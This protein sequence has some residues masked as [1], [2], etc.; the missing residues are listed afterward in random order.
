MAIKVT[1][2]CGKKLAVKDEFAGRQVKCPACQKMLSLPKH[3]V[4]EESLDD[5]WDLEDSTE[6]E[7]PE[8]APVKS[9]SAKKSAASGSVSRKGKAKSKKSSG[10][11][12][13]LLI[14]LSGGG[15]L[16]VA[17]LV[18]MFWPAGPAG[19]VAGDPNGGASGNPA[20]TN[21]DPENPSNSAPQMVDGVLTLKGHN[22]WV[23]CVAFSPDG[24]RLA[25]SSLM[26]AGFSEMSVKVWDTTSG[27]ETFTFKGHRNGI[28]RVVW[29]PDGKRIVSTAD[30]TKVWDSTSGKELLTFSGS[31]NLA[32]SP[33][34]RSSQTQRF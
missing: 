28:N 1:G 17:L 8:P 29:F 2:A 22:S 16:V 5:E 10:Q 24:K 14:G 12:R 23:T 30:T 25:S 20:N 6:D 9:R 15:V 31:H 34:A 13:G 26:G 18:W 32:I 7:E 19:K 33:G 21:G 11:N 3:K 4:Q 27:Q